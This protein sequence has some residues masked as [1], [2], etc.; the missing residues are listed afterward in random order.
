M[1]QDSIL[2]LPSTFRSFSSYH[3]QEYLYVVL[4][5]LGKTYPLQMHMDCVSKKDIHNSLETFF[6]FFDVFQ[7]F[8]PQ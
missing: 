6:D 5:S 3:S 4:V 1:P 7:D 8:G 2:T